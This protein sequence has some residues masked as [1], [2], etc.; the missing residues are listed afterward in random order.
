MGCEAGWRFSFLICEMRTR[1]SVFNVHPKSSPLPAAPR[2]LLG[3][4]DWRYEDGH[5]GEVAAGTSSC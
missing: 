3:D 5:A 2:L 4:G 1:L